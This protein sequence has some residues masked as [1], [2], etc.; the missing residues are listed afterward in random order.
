MTTQLSEEQVKKIATLAAMQLSA[1]EIAKFRGWLS[2][3][4]NY[5][6]VLEELD[7]SQTIETSQVTGLIN[8]WQ[9]DVAR[10]SLTQAQALKNAPRTMRGYFKVDPALER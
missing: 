1:D 9:A 4:I 8:V 3:A 7:T 10:P 2:Q 6:A 5:V